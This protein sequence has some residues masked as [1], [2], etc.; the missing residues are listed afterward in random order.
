MISPSKKKYLDLKGLNFGVS[1]HFSIPFLFESLLKNKT[2]NYPTKQKLGLEGA[3]QRCLRVCM[4]QVWQW[5]AKEQC[6]PHL[7]GSS[8]CKTTHYFNHHTNKIINDNG[9]RRWKIYIYMCVNIYIYN[10]SIY[11]YICMYIY[12]CIY[13]CIYIYMYIYICIYICI[14]IYMYVCIYIIVC[15]YIYIYMYMYI[16]MYIYI[17]VYVYIYICIN[18]E[19]TF[20][21][22][23]CF[24]P[25]FGWSNLV[26]QCSHDQ[27]WQT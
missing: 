19:I 26:I 21:F 6:K 12:I 16:Y 18:I 1:I 20:S 27:I 13:I 5:S 11:I 8:L 2:L 7:D 23:S 3:I 9:G 10:V 4:F 22:F 15:M 14:Y 17:Y 24:T 25:V